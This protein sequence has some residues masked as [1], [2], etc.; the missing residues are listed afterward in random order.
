MKKKQTASDVIARMQAK[1][2]ID[3][4]MDRI[5]TAYAPWQPGEWEE[6]RASLNANRETG[7]ALVNH[8]C[9][10]SA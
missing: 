7:M 5:K 3:S 9:G 4:K 6:F 2:S 8:L 1:A 10:V